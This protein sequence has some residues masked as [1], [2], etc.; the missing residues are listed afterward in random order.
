MTTITINELPAIDEAQSTLDALTHG[1]GRRIPVRFGNDLWTL[2]CIASQKPWAPEIVLPLAVS[3]E[4]AHL[5]LSFSPGGSLFERHAEFR[6]IASM[7]EPFAMAI[8]ATLS[9]EILD[10]LQNALDAPV[11]ISKPA[12]NAPPLAFYFDILNAEGSREGRGAMRIGPSVLEKIQ[13]VSTSWEGTPNKEIEEWRLPVAICV[14][15]IDIPASILAA[16]RPGDC[17]MVG[18]LAAWPFPAFLSTGAGISPANAKLQS[19]QPPLYNLQQTATMNNTE[20]QPSALD[21][22]K[23]PV[24][25]VAGRKALTLAEIANLREGANIEI[26]NDSE[27]PV[28]IEVNNQTIA[29]GRLVRV[30]DKVCAGITEIVSPAKA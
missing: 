14:A 2:Q 15:A 8:R 20:S 19:P 25:I 12:T 16:M 9:R 22:L 1:A 29:R 4:P 28:E 18:D 30:G 6:D 13:S 21:G 11:E 7:S 27:I 10:S 17:L 23:L 5:E 3:G 24:L 26:G